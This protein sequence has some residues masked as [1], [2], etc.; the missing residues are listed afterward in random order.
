MLWPRTDNRESW[1]SGNPPIFILKLNRA[2]QS[3]TNM[4]VQ[5]NFRG[6]KI[7]AK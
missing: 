5:F 3:E 7:K 1:A 4:D 6:N 2:H